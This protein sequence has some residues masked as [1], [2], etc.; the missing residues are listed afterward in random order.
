MFNIQKLGSN[1][2]DQNEQIFNAPPLNK[3]NNNLPVLADDQVEKTKEESLQKSLKILK[4]EL[5]QEEPVKFVIPKVAV[6]VY[7]QGQNDLEVVEKR[8]V[9]QFLD[10]QAKKK[11]IDAFIQMGTRTDYKILT[12][13]DGKIIPLFQSYP[14][15]PSPNMSKPEVLANFVYSFLALY[16]DAPIKVLDLS[17]HGGGDMGAFSND[18]FSDKTEAMMTVDGIGKAIKKGVELYE[19]KTGKKAKF[20]LVIFDQCLMSN[21]SVTEAMTNSEAVNYY[22]A[23]P[24]VTFGIG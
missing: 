8:I 20:D 14:N 9:A 5:P 19:A 21:L 16:G 6:G 18:I 17:N 2:G 24:E 10:E 1:L 11:S 15:E 12:C 7:S 3:N 23:S 13:K 22:L 4:A